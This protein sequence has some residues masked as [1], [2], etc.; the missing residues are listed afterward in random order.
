LQFV[1]HLMQFPRVGVDGGGTVAFVPDLGLH[2]LEP[3]GLPEALTSCFV[4]ATVSSSPL[5][6]HGVPFQ[7]VPIVTE[8]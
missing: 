8:L 6:V 7:Q 1:T 3:E 4:S 5:G 2:Y